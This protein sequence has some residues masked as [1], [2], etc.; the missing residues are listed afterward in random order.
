MSIR[1][2]FST[3]PT[4]ILSAF[5]RWGTDCHISHV[6]FEREDGW[7]LGS[8]FPDGVQ[9]RPPEANAR[10]RCVEHRTFDRIDEAYEWVLKNRLG[11]CYNTLAIFGIITARDWHSNKCRFCSE[12]IYEGAEAVGTYL[13]NRD[14]TAWWQIRPIDL[15]RSPA[16]KLEQP[17]SIGA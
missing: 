1:L 17:I 8:R 4:S 5:I 14:E 12:A 6:E 7:T 10:Q 15:L 2:R 16:V 11:W 13:L 9:L 3:E